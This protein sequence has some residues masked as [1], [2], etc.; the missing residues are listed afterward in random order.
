MML[1]YV[2]SSGSMTW[3]PR[4]VDGMGCISLERAGS[5]LAELQQR[6]GEVH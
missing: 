6:V 4:S 3:G 1:K 5:H 2:E